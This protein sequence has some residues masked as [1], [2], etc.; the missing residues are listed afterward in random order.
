MK[1]KKTKKVMSNRKFLGINLP[2]LAFIMVVA[3]ALNYFVIKSYYTI[4]IY[5]T[6]NTGASF[7][8]E[9]AD[10]A[11]ANAKEVSLRIEAEGV[12]LMKNEN[13]VLPLNTK[14]NNKI[15]VFGWS[16]H[17]MVL[18]GTGSGAAD[19]T[20]AV[21]FY[22]AL[23]TEGF[24]IYQPLADFYKEYKADRQAGLAVGN[25]DMTIYEASISKDYKA[26]LLDGA[27]AWSDTAVVVIG[28]VGG[29][30]ND[31]PLDYLT[32]SAEEQ[33]LLDY[34]GKNFEKT[35]V[36]LNISNVIEV[37]PIKNNPNID[38]IMWV[39]L[40]GLVGNTSI[41]QAL[42]GTVNPSGRL[43]DTYAV[44]FKKDPTYFNAG[45]LG[46]KTY[47]DKN[48]CHYI[49]YAEGIYVGYRYYETAAFEGYINYDE[50]VAYPFGYGL[51]YTTF[52]Q[53]LQ[54]VREKDGEIEVKVKVTNTGD[55]AGK[56]VAQV[57]FTAPYDKAENIEKAYVEL[58]GFAKT[59][60]LAP[61]KSETLT[62][63]FD[64]DDMAAFDYLGEQAYVLS[65]GDYEIKLMNNSHDLIASEKYS[66]K[67]TAVYKDGKDG[68][69]SSDLIAAVG[70][71]G[72]ADG[73]KET[74]PVKYMTRADMTLPVATEA[75][76]ASDAVKATD[77]ASYKN[78]R[79]A[80][81]TY[82]NE[83]VT[84]GVDAGIKF[85]DMAGVPF[86]DPKWDDFMDQLTVQEMID[87]VS[88]GGY[89]NEAVE[90]VEKPKCLDFDGPNGFNN[91]N[92]TST[93]VAG[94]WGV[95]YPNET[96][97]ASSF[98]EEVAHLWGEALGIESQNY[99]IPGWYAPGVNI[100]RSPYDGRNFEYF[101]E[102]P[103]LSGKISAKIVHGAAEYG[104]YCYVKHFAANETETDRASN[105]LFTWTNE[106]AL[107]EIY[108]VPF[109]LSVKEGGT[110]A[111]MSSFN[112]IGDKW[113]GN[114]FELLTVV[115]RN[116]WGFHGTVIT[117]YYMSMQAFMNPQ[118]SIVAGNDLLL[119]GMEFLSP[120]WSDGDL[121]DPI[122]QQAARRAA[123]NIFYTTANSNAT[124]SSF[125]LKGEES[126]LTRTLLIIIDSVLL[127]II[128]LYI[129]LMVVRTRKH[130]KYI[131]GIIN[132]RRGNA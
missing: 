119:T 35:V 37:A 115:L 33:E 61:G 132:Q 130:E 27:K 90:S 44:D 55:V 125:A 19:V 71:F 100:H 13:K 9:G 29:E 96:V 83:P 23:K 10:A 110:T 95:A 92:A 59:E 48:N 111:I 121:S 79:T 77:N 28:R 68:K 53:E 66:V 46:S 26:E 123:K 58:A 109:E 113:A 4:E 72:Y 104:L 114:N 39:G 15:A 70:V 24:D 87:L 12:V 94:G 14:S 21:T 31:L 47:T 18:G 107:R 97:V 63:T 20:N 74:V 126:H 50:A 85:K 38:A 101:S 89:K 56:E 8:G 67:K 131:M 42:S 86:D 129:T 105:G 118:W 117:D 36:L 40:P 98:S 93:G 51:S 34:V 52:K 41:A 80:I 106:Q 30:G 16:S 3:V 75:R 32:L 76:A 22:D 1:E 108:L 17:G 78:D 11:R 116:E 64:V 65:A 6:G 5:L 128:V 49:D 99:N 57:Y 91:Q 120:K 62:I 102:D 69:R 45:I 60:L 88:Y 103:L 124:G 112:R 43:T 127:A 7:T 82:E 81:A 73:S 84:T 25:T 2:I 122:I 54:S